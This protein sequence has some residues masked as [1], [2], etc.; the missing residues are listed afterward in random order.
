M[1]IT[2]EVLQQRYST[3]SD[4]ALL[5][6]FAA[7]SGPY[8][9]LAWE[10][11]QE[12]VAARGLAPASAPAAAAPPPKAPSPEAARRPSP[13]SGTPAA[14]PTPKAP[15]PEAARKP[16]PGSGAPVATPTPKASS[17]K[18]ARGP[19]TPA[20]TPASKAQP[21]EA[22]PSESISPYFL[23]SRPRGLRWSAD[24]QLSLAARDI[25]AVA[26][27]IFGVAGV[28]LVITAFVLRGPAAALE[29]GVLKLGGVI[30][31][32]FAFA[33]SARRPPAPWTWWLAMVYCGISPVLALGQIGTTA[34]EYGPRLGLEVIVGLLWLLY[35]ARRRATY[36]LAPWPWLW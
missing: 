32:S 29:P 18:A 16:S 30:G 14:T 13:G 20:P 17:V 12:M 7:G 1:E 22:A 11:I 9:P 2:K 26:A 21:L 19:A 34:I 28:A 4:K 15:F 25:I 6:A 31:A 3:F 27:L 36:G 24:D 35:F 23:V 8:S 5:A 33:Y 10:V